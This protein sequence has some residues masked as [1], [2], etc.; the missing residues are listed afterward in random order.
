MSV[1]LLCPACNTARTLAQSPANNACEACGVHYPEPVLRAA[2]ES[3]RLE[4]APRPLLLTLGMW[5][6][7]LWA[8]GAGLFLLSD[9][10][11]HAATYSVNGVSVSRDEFY[12]QPVALLLPYL[13]AYC[14][15]VT[16]ALR[17]E[18]LWARPLMAV[19]WPRYIIAALAMPDASTDQ[20]TTAVLVSLGS[21]ATG[22]WYLY[23]KATVRSYFARLR[24]ASG[25]R[26]GG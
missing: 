2:L 25:I 11:S 7:G 16:W 6:C 24:D 9:V 26:A 8:A 17:H 18:R 5:F 13:I 19:A 21:A 20:R 10:F 15:A 22:L 3:L 1:V 4:F 23:R 14:G 12:R